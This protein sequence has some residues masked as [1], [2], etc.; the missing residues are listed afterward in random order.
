M[1]S[2]DLRAALLAG[3]LSR[4]RLTWYDESAGE[5]ID[6]SG[7]TLAN[8]VAKA[9][10][11]LET[12]MA[13]APGDRFGLL[14]PP[15]HDTALRGEAG[16]VKAV[17]WSAPIPLARIKEAGHHGGATVN[18]VI[19]AAV[20][21]ALRTHLVRRRSP[22]HDIRAIVPFNLRP[23]DEPLPE[24][25]GVSVR[26]DLVALLEFLRRRG[27]GRRSGALMRGMLAR[28]QSQPRLWDAYQETVIRSRREALCAVLRRGM[29]TGE[30]RSDAEPALLAD[31][32][33]GPVLMSAL[34]QEGEPAGA[35]ARPEHV[36][37]LLL[38]GVRG[39]TRDA[40]AP[41][42]I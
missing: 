13:L 20:A 35:A 11:W 16:T 34:L 28:F 23:L 27:T 21:G 15:D 6:L 1:N 40:R 14:I 42:R 38:E 39:Q 26:D 36:V 31:L 8:W 9:A 29:A 7:K 22:V 30:I 37:D 41:D 10:N 2:D 5:R 4:P 33:A 17:T 3:D 25:A 18:D 19:L 32:F 12:E 24:P